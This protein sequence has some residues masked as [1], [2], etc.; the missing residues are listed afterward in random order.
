M[1]PGASRRVPLAVPGQ[2]EFKRLWMA[3]ADAHPHR[4]RTNDGSSPPGRDTNMHFGEHCDPAPNPAEQ[5]QQEKGNIRGHRRQPHGA[6]TP[7][8]RL[9]TNGKPVARFAVVTSRRVRDCQSG[10]WSDADTSFWACV[11]FGELWK[12]VMVTCEADARTDDLPNSLRCRNVS[13]PAYGGVPW[14]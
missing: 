1:Q 3:M 12:M 7:E 11:A 9:S 8:L 10:E 2:R 14:G 6:V 13:P 4:S 5:R